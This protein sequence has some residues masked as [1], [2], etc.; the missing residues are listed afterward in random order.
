MALNLP[1][2]LGAGLQQDSPMDLFGQYFQGHE[3]GGLP[4]R[5]RQEAMQRAFDTQTKGAQAE[6]AREKEQATIA[7]MLREQ[8]MGGFTGSLRNLMELEAYANS[9]NA[10]P[11][12]VEKM[13]EQL[14]FERMR[15]QGKFDYTQKMAD[16]FYYR[17]ST[18]TQKKLMEIDALSNGYTYDLKGNEVE[19]TPEEARKKRNVLAM[20]VYK[21]VSD[22]DLRKRIRY[23]RNLDTTL[24]NI[25]PEKAFK[26]SGGLGG[27]AKKLQQGRSALTGRE[28]KEYREF[29]ENLSKLKL[30]A[31][32]ASQFFDVG[33]AQALQEGVEELLN[34]NTWTKSPEVAMAKYNAIVNLFKQEYDN[35][36][37]QGIDP[38]AYGFT[39]G[40]ESGSFSGPVNVEQFGNAISNNSNQPAIESG[41]LIGI[42]PDGRRVVVPANK[43][44]EFIAKGGRRG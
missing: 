23:A 3:R 17:N 4:E 20:D 43:I 2:F 44:D 13:R 30:A 9:P 14:A 37:K 8:R 41:K 10:D 6:F 16:T 31:K 29:E 24:H 39:Y 22:E 34:P 21:S 7:K 40:D 1:N 32:Q 18:A 15:E 35:L 12:L 25:D 27:I 5:L 42:T 33:A 26:Y 11:A 19:V 38:S 28:D 36:I